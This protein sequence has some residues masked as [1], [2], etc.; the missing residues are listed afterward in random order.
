LILPRRAA[1]SALEDAVAASSVLSASSATTPYPPMTRGDAF[2]QAVHM[3]LDEAY[4]LA[5]KCLAANGCDQSNSVAVAD[6]II[7]AERDGCASHG[8]FRL[9]GHVASL[10]SGKVNGA[11]KP[12]CERLASGVVRVQGDR[13]F[14][15]TAQRVGIPELVR[16]ARGQGV[17]ALALVNIFHFS[18]LWVE[19]EAIA[20]QGVCAFALTSYLPA[21]APAGGVRPLFGTNPLAFGWPRKNQPPLVFDQAS[22]ARAK[23]E[24]MIAA[25]DGHLLPDGVGIDKDGRPTRDPKAVL[26]GA[27]L[28]FGGYKGSAIAL[29]IELLAGP[30][31][32]EGLSF[33]TAETDNRDGGPPR[34]GELIIAIDPGRFGDPDNYLAHGERLFERMLTEEGVRLP[35]ARRQAQRARTAKDG[36]LVEA[37][38][39]ET[40]VGLARAPA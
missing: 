3:S 24:V 12:F 2:M 19:I 33:E 22:A 20:E 10:R 25:R 23:G 15:P 6:T 9:P 32:G 7:A 27:I 16:T 36:I 8:L 17:A 39:H 1:I 34:G 26:D 35:G 28:P 29:M 18:A 21:V 11:A 13:G 4:D 37:K 40:I 14:A 5:L 31:M 38:L 30:L